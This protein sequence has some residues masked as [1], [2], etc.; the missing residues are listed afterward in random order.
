MELARDKAVR[1]ARDVHQLPEKPL[2]GDLVLFDIN[3]ELLFRLFAAEPELDLTGLD[4]FAG[5]SRRKD[6]FERS[7]H[8]GAVLSFHPGREGDRGR[9]VRV[10]AVTAVSHRKL[11]DLLDLVGRQLA[12]VLERYTKALAYHIAFAERHQNKAPCLQRLLHPVGNLVGER[13]VQ[14]VI[15]DVDDDFC[16]SAQVSS[17]ISLIST[18]SSM[19]YLC[20]LISW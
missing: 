17:R 6:R 16:E 5:L 15:G 20:P 12:V 13:P 10:F 2:A 3:S 8:S 9:A 18:R 19:G 11:G 14:L 4:R 1:L 7:C